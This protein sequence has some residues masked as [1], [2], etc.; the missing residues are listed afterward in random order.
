MHWKRPIAALV[1][2][3]AALFVA[4]PANAQSA[5]LSLWYDEPAR[6]WE[7]EGLPIGNGAMGAMLLGGV[8]TDRIQ[9]NEKT[10]WTG[11]PGSAEGYDFGLPDA[12]HAQAVR[13][14]RDE[15]ERKT[16][17][18][19][20]RVAA[21]L[22]RRARGY[23]HYQTFGDLVL[24]FPA[25]EARDYR[26]E[27]D[28]QRAIARVSY[29]RDG[30]R[31]VREYF[32]SYP[33]SV[34]VVRLSADRPGQ[35]SFRASL[36]IPDNRSRSL[37][38]RRGRL[39]AS[40]ALHDNRL[41]YEAQVQVIAEGG[42]RRDAE[43]AVE[44]SGA[45][46]ALIVLSAGT[47]YALRY[48]KY[49]GADPHSRI[50]MLVDR[51]AAKG[52]ARLRDDHVRDHRALFDRV[53]LDIGQ[54]T[55]STPTDEALAAYSGGSSASDR[56][57]ETL[58]FQYGRY[59][60]IASSRRGSLPANLQGV[61]NHSTTPPWNG[62][63]HVNINLQMNYWLAETTNLAETAA[64]LFDFVDELTQP[65]AVSARNIFGARG[66]TLHLN[67]NPWGFAGLID[68]PTAFWQPEAGAW[69]AQHYYEHYRFSG[70]R[71]FLARRAYPVMKEAARFWLDALVVDPRDGS[72]VVSPSYSPEHGPFSAGAAMSQ[73]I[74]FDLFSN[75]A[76]AA[77]LLGDGAFR[78]EISAALAR[79]DPGLRVG[80]WG[81]LQE[82]KEDWDERGDDHRHVS[83]LFALH[84]G[85]RISPSATPRLAEAAR[86]SLDARGD[87]GTGWSK[88]WKINFWARLHDGDRAHRL[89]AEQLRAST[90]PNLLDTHPPFQI[91]G[92]FGA[93][94]GVAEMLLQSQSDEIHI[95]PALPR[96]WSSGAVQGLRARGG[97]TIDVRWANGLASEIVL[98]PG[99]SQTIHL[100]TTIFQGAFTLT[101]RAG[102]QV[103]TEREARGRAFRAKQGGRYTLRAAHTFQ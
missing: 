98:T 31:Y 63:Y 16:R 95:L 58:Y 6:D 33:D 19:P 52:Y 17:L 10:L 68:W 26:R 72:L 4:A 34:V 56:A 54:A 46:S 90:L 88:A 81:Q 18:E 91:D 39:V 103:Q 75:V 35:I 82:W 38:V 83:H 69:L 8:E 70:D 89:L 24:A 12:S 44:V 30:V 99:R 22:G 45:D 5:A 100:R 42:A 61:W 21:A 78:S 37:A 23:G 74:V 3:C 73:Q 77:G 94:A 51:A 67:T 7:R 66:W 87:G 59:L 53:S 11:G 29:V 62:D 55:T 96:A 71:A 92:N 101:D 32:A 2:L 79:L 13:N 15:I 86:T 14:V 57:L 27:L 9:F 49:R 97:V 20:E 47:D 80:S 1:V 84:P 50:G 64:P 43:G 102:R 28:I 65:G 40:G 48:P 41:R 36:E 25:G 93:A 85:R 76:E 60:L